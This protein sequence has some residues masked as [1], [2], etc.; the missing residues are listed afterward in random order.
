V[1]FYKQNPAISIEIQAFES[2]GNVPNVGF[3]SVQVL[4]TNQIFLKSSAG[5][6]QS[7]SLLDKIESN[8]TS[9]L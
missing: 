6:P 7:F 2:F 9:D 1:K 8:L 3:A 4:H 5:G